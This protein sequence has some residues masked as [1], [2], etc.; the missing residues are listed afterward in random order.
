[1]LLWRGDGG[2]L[3]MVRGASSCR[4]YSCCCW[5]AA[6]VASRRADVA[7]VTRRCIDDGRGNSRAEEGGREDAGGVVA[8]NRFQA[9]PQVWRDPRMLQSPGDAE[10]QRTRARVGLEGRCVLRSAEAQ[11]KSRNWQR[12]GAR[13]ASRLNQFGRRGVVL[14][15][16]VVRLMIQEAVQLWTLLPPKPF[17]SS[18]QQI[19]QLTARDARI[20]H[21]QSIHFLCFLQVMADGIAE[22]HGVPGPRIVALEHPG[23]IRN[24]DNGLKSLGGEAQ[25]KHVSTVF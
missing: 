6:G 11:A 24:F 12:C 10:L 20:N 14:A 17:H 25:L 1:M 7:H 8:L 22:L 9:W 15:G 21:F 4:P 13:I 23:I 16:G 5:I 19:P 18:K 3:M 2:A